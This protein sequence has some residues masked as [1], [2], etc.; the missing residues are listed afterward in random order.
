MGNNFIFIENQVVTPAKHY[1]ASFF[2]QILQL[3]CSAFWAHY[4]LP[5]RIDLDYHH[6]YPVAS[7]KTLLPLLVGS[8]FCRANVPHMHGFLHACEPSVLPEFKVKNVQK[9][10]QE[11]LPCRLCVTNMGTGTEL[12]ETGFLFTFIQSITEGESIISQSSKKK[13]YK[14]TKIFTS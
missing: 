2:I 12:M 9:N 8:H 13:N 11:C 6:M 4:T 3:G 7:V 5:N 10:L 1:S 14:R